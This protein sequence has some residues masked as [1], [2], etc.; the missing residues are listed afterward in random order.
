MCK[1]VAIQTNWSPIPYISVPFYLTFFKRRLSYVY[2]LALALKLHYSDK[3]SSKLD[4]LEPNS[5]FFCCNKQ[6]MSSCD[7]HFFCP[8]RTAPRGCPKWSQ[9]QWLDISSTRLHFHRILPIF[10]KI[11]KFFIIKIFTLIH[12]LFLSWQGSY[13]CIQV[14][15]N[16]YCIIQIVY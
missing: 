14:V 2:V 4:E 3:T 16:Y 13:V 7:N 12:Y 15:I 1:Q 9:Y 5:V 8:F 11:L 6:Y 10:F